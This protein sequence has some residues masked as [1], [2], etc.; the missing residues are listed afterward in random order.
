MRLAHVITLSLVGALGIWS[1]PPAG[2][3]E[4]TVLLN[5]ATET[6]VREMAAAYE[7][8]TGNKINVSFEVGAA[9]YRKISTGGP[10]DLASLGMGQFDELLKNGSVLAGSVVEYGRVGNGV[11]IKAGALK[12][13]ISTPDGF[14][15]AMLNA[16]SIGH[17]NAG[18]G[19]F[20]TRLFQKLGIYDQIKGKIKII[21][22]KLVA[23]AVADGDVEIGIQQTNVIQPYPGSEYLG[24]L[25]PALMEYGGVGIG[26]LKASQHPDE[27]RAFAKFMG[28]P[29]NVGLL[30]KAAMEPP[31]KAAMQA[32]TR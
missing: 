2:A 1:V 32:L 12:R 11:A 21:D 31:A 26:V 18:T 25:P 17:T 22:G 3:V 27:A 15:Q 6:G 19:P 7:K 10:G 20:N 23:A 5:Q 13:D 16:R 29:A 8:A 4:L 14:K 9:L 28:D 30:I 24:P